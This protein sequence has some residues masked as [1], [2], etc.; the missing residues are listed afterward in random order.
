MNLAYI[1]GG[2]AAIVLLLIV[3]IALQAPG[4]HI[5]RST[6]IPA[7]A[8]AIFPHVNDL[9][10]WDA[11]S[12]WAKLDPAMKQTYEG[13]P[14][15]AGASYT[16]NGNNQVGEGRTT[17]TESRPCDF[18]RLKLDFVRPFKGTNDVEFTFKPEGE[19]TVVTWSMT[20]KK[21]FMAKAVHM[22]MNMDK[23]C[24]GQFEQ[25]L[26]KLKDVVT[27]PAAVHS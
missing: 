9:H 10:L 25:G 26:A 17:I 16:W 23:M 22:I 8:S 6:A 2:V 5:A 7:P 1:L 18:V 11:W 13:A 19:Q 21:N 15:G 20:G 24:G 4:F 27:T 14:A 12:P 3:V